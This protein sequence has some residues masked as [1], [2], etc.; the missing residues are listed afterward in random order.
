MGTA[1]E[2]ARAVPAA[3]AGAEEDA[4]FIRPLAVGRGGGSRRKWPCCGGLCAQVIRAAAACVCARPAYPCMRACPPLSVCVFLCCLLLR[5]SPVP[6]WSPP[7]SRPC[8][9]RGAVGSPWW[10]CGCLFCDGGERTHVGSIHTAH[11]S[12]PC[13]SAHARTQEC[14]RAKESQQERDFLPN[15]GP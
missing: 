10:G 1:M 15:E 13:C 7:A 2:P 12:P 4:P 5:T 3:V 11:K 8:G 14:G 9:R 6:L